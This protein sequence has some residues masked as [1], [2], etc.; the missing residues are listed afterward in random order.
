LHLGQTIAPTPGQPDKTPM[1]IPLRTALIGADRGGEVA[2]EQLILLDSAEQHITFDNVPE[3]PLLS[4]NRG[5]SAPVIVDVE[6]GDDDL[7]RLAEH[8][9]DPFARYEAMQELM[10]RSLV[11]GARNEALDTAPIVRAVAGTLASP[12]LDVA[13]K[14][15]AIFIP[16][17]N[18]IADRMEAV[19]PDAIH[20]SRDALRA[21][22]GTALRDDLLRVRSGAQPAGDDLSGDAKG[23][24]RLRS[25]AL[26]LLAAGDPAEG[27]AIAK[28]QFDAADN[29]T[30]RQNA[31]SVL[32]SLDAP[33]RTEALDAF[34]DRFRDDPLVVDKWFTLQ[35]LA[36]R[37]QTIDDVERLAT[38]P[39]F[40][41]ANPNRL[42]AL[43]SSFAANPWAFNHASGRGYRFVADMILA[44]DKL[45]PQ[46]AARLV[47]P[48]GR[49]RRMEPGRS[50]LMR[51]ELERIA[52]TPG[53]SKDVFEQAS[54]SLT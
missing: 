42:R 46:V 19:D 43:A 7:E 6:R 24:R 10:M 20:A 35:G 37:S 26:G 13:F 9:R 3:R 28:A 50:S 12:T 22:L 16:S 14:G 54:K 18:I 44:A 36:Q 48:L 34:Y 52:G 51:A 30:D 32:V 45:N 17:E 8:D 27:A 31:L 39:A 21:A 4:I 15:E 47:P 33:E 49:W 1:P 40:N 53:L 38:H 25:V 41:I 2:P 11:A 29:M 5:F 23:L